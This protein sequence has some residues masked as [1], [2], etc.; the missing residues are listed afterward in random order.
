MG[1]VRRPGGSYRMPLGFGEVSG[2]RNVPSELKLDHKRFP[3]VTRFSVHFRT[4][5]ALLERQLPPGLT[6]AGEPIATLYFS[7]M[8][9][10]EWLAGRDYNVLSFS[11]PA[12]FA[13]ERDSVTAHF[14]SVLWESL[15]DPVISGREDLGF[16]KLWCEIPD[17]RIISGRHTYEASWQGFRFIEAVFEEG[18]DVA[19][20][21]PVPGQAPTTGTISHKYIP[22]TG[23]R[24][25]ADLD[26]L[27][28]WPQ[29]EAS[30][31]TRANVGTGRFCLNRARWE[32]LPTMHHVING[33]ADLPIEVIRA[34]LVWG[35]GQGD[36]SN[37]TILE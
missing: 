3:L 15:P 9:Q 26:Q 13:G 2:A 29:F 5:P 35:S 31:V 36:V 4:D 12:T 17:P 37:L 6:L 1:F 21:P 19:A 32:D 23:E 7:T 22:R 24:G 20:L 18:E 16:P 27:I 10:I 30:G 8:K 11:F 34:D 25:V 33:L 28:Y 14:K